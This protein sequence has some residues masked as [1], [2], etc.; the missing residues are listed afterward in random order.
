MMQA[1]E[2]AT[3]IASYAAAVLNV[4]LGLTINQ[5]CMVIGAFC[6]L[7]TFTVNWWY[8]RREHR[9]TLIRLRLEL[10]ESPDAI[11]REEAL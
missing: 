1:H 6:A 7:G 5:W 10:G 2:H 11:R 4:W 3:T 9:I 8:K